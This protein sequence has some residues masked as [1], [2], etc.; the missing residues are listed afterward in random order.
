MRDSGDYQ[1]VIGRDALQRHAWRE[2]FERLG[3]A[4]A[5]KP[6]QPEDLE[7]LA[8][9]A[10]WVGQL[11]GCIAVRERTHAAYLERGDRRRAGFMALLLGH[12]HF[13]KSQTSQANGWMR[14]A[15]QLLAKEGDSVSSLR[16]L[17][18]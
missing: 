4:D 14:R 5:A 3:A 18:S 16:R 7:L 6:L 9:A 2:A 17:P 13:A 8:Q 15:E 1:L 11:D 12:D 10:W